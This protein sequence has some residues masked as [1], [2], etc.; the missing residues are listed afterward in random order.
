MQTVHIIAGNVGLGKAIQ[1]KAIMASYPNIVHWSDDDFCTMMTLDRTLIVEESSLIKNTKMDFITRAIQE[2]KSVVVEGINATADE[3]NDI[4]NCCIKAGNMS[5]V[6]VGWDF[7]AGD[8]LSLS[9][10]MSIPSNNHRAWEDIHFHY[11]GVYEPIT[12]DELFHE[13]ITEPTF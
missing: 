12:D 11:L 1:S 4:I 10:K 5:I 13:V 2:G 6:I 9:K 8:N 3:R 7:G